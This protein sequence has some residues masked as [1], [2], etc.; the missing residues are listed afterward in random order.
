MRADK[1]SVLPGLR[2][3][4]HVREAHE[5]S[6]RRAAVLL[7]LAALLWFHEWVPL[8]L[9]GT[10]V[11]WVVLHKGLESDRGR[12]LVRRWRRLWPP[13]TAAL[14]L[15]LVAGTLA[16]WTSD[17]PLPTRVLPIALN[18]LA[19]SVIMFGNWWRIFTKNPSG[20]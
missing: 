4:H 3:G 11:V 9:V 1:T 8:L 19:L 6:R 20:R 7:I 13:A 5:Q 2:P 16:Y 12:E 18:G 15:V 14:V 17:Q 10:G